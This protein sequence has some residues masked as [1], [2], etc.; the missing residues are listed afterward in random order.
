ME[1]GKLRCEFCRYEFE[2]ESAQNL[3]QDITKL[4]GKLVASGA[5][6]IQEGTDDI[7]TLKC[8]SC[9][10][11]VVIDTKESAQARC[12]W[13]RNTL[14]INE[15]V[16]NGSVPDVVLPFSVKRDE[17]KQEIE[18]F[19]GSRMFFAHPD[20]KKEF[21]TE[22]VMGVYFPYM[23]VDVNGK[24]NFSGEGEHLVREYEVKFGDDKETRYDADLYHVE[25]KF[26]I[27]IKEL[28]I[29]SSSDK[30]NR[31]HRQKTNN[32]INAIMPCDT[33]KCVQWNA[34]Y[35][36]GY[37]SEKR[38]TDVEQLEHLVLAQSK[39]IAKYKINDTLKHY[40]RGVRWYR[41]DLTL[42]GQ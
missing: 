34:N 19:V 15:K 14:S 2:P 21:T 6:K 12:H 5:S 20:F 42:E 37:T 17:A 35:L 38:D 39:D 27:A 3:E 18:K 26:D 1:T 40:D 11:E 8:D 13:C 41:K 33:D 36:K 10:S 4:K 32:L 16:P 7:I 24:A 25:R 31:N 28:S 22:N 9:G 30:L 29:E 23:L